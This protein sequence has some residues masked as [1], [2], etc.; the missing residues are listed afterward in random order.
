MR[1]ERLGANFLADAPTNNWLPGRIDLDIKGVG[2][3]QHDLSVCV[4]SAAIKRACLDD[5]LAGNHQTL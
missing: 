2:G 4:P 5:I 1:R 3:W